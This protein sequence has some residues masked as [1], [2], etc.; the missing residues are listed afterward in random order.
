MTIASLSDYDISDPFSATVVGLS[1]LTPESSQE[2]VLEIT[3]ALEDGFRGLKPGENIGV[4]VPG[5]HAFGNREHFRLYTVASLEESE[6][7]RETFTIC[8]RRCDYIDE[9]N[10]ERYQGVASNYL[11][12]RRLGE[13]IRFTGPYPS[14]FTMPADPNANILMIAMGTGIAPFRAFVRNL[15]HEHGGWQGK[16][17]LFYGAQSGLEMLYMNDQRNDFANY[18]DKE[19]FKAFQAVSPRPHRN[20]PIA[21]EQTFEENAEEVSQLLQDSNTYVYIAGLTI[22]RVM[23]SNTFAKLMGSHAERNRRLEEMKA[24]SRW[25]ELLY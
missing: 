3:V 23:L 9:I 11:C 19:T 5:P 2:E 12:D 13:A 4:L 7:D 10:G 18:Y 20:D 6:D 24:G 8:V 16:V 15:Y 14:P 17:R 1:R 25:Q 21:F 22:M